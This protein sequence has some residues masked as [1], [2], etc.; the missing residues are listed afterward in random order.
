MHSLIVVENSWV[1]IDRRGWYEATS[2]RDEGWDGIDEWRGQMRGWES[3]HLPYLIV[4]HFSPTGK[5]EGGIKPR[6]ERGRMEHYLGYLPIFVLLSGIRRMFD[7]PY[8]I[9][10]IAIVV[11]YM[12]AWLHQEER[13]DEPD[14]IVFNRKQQLRRMTFGLL[15][16]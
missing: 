14:L 1:P 7:W 6:L 15:G 5:R 4:K 3:R 11:G 13:I 9:G 16:R 8:V 12:E 10:G 2:L